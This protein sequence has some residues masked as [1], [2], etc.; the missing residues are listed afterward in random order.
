MTINNTHQLCTMRT[1]CG[2]RLVAGSA[3]CR[4]SA[5]WPLL[6]PA[7]LVPSLLV[8]KKDTI[9]LF[10]ANPYTQWGHQLRQSSV[11]L[12]NQRWLSQY[13]TNSSK[14][15]RLDLLKSSVVCICYRVCSEGCHFKDY[16]CTLYNN[17][18]T[19]TN[20]A[21]AQYRLAQPPQTRNIPLQISWNQHA[22]P[23]CHHLLQNLQ[24]WSKNATQSLF[25]SW[26]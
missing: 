18:D 3:H 26:M 7:L 14:D 15:K 11:T 5:E 21:H 24:F 10:F 4:A 23:F 25:N 19:P 16:I 13:L 2:W 17:T 6:T 8:A 20:P 22:T 9:C 1:A 12:K